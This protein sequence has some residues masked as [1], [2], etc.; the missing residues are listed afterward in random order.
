MKE[1]TEFFSNNEFTDVEKVRYKLDEKDIE[2][3]NKFR[4]FVD[5]DEIFSIRIYLI[6]N[7]EIIGFDDEIW[8]LDGCYIDVYNT[9]SYIAVYEK[10]TQ[11][12]I[13]IPL[14]ELPTNTSS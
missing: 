12:L 2:N 8:R 9:H 14:Y 11:E 6:G 13:T 5:Q 10:H 7:V 3:I 1:T 4:Q